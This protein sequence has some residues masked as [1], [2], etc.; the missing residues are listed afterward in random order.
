MRREWFA[1]YITAMIRVAAKCAQVSVCYVANISAVISWAPACRAVVVQTLSYSASLSV[2]ISQTLLV[3]CLHLVSGGQW[4]QGHKQELMAGLFL[5]SFP[6]LPF[7]SP[8][9][10]VGPFKPA[11]RSGEHCKLPQWGQ[12]QS[13][14]RKR[15]WCTLNLS[16]SH[17]WQSFWVYS[18]VHVL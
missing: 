6:P 9:L 2:D 5:F 12:G 1:A 15:I 3:V 11:R 13:S 18:E 10:E 16:E 4:C 14:G 8:P 7:S 17:R